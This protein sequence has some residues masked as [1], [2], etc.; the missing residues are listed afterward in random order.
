[1]LKNCI[2]AADMTREELILDC[3]YYNGEETYPEGVDSLMWGYEEAWVRMVLEN[4]P[5]PQKCIDYYTKRYD[6]PSILPYEKDGTPLGIKAILWNRCDH[7][8]GYEAVTA[9]SFIRWYQAHYVK[10]TKTHRQLLND[11]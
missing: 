1:M 4:N 2:F 9:E 3:R 5:T 6:L 8:S 11:Q 10:D 7:W